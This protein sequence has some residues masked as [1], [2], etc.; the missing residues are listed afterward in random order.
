MIVR[1]FKD[2]ERFTS[3]WALTR[4]DEDKFDYTISLV[5]RLVGHDKRLQALFH[6]LV[7]LTP[8]STDTPLAIQ[9]SFL[10]AKKLSFQ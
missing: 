9:V 2:Q 1:I 7:M 6:M 10:A 4:A 5:G 8:D 3:P